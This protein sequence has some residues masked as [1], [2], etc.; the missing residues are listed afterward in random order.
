M[1]TE[2]KK[3]KKVVKQRKRRKAYEKQR[4]IMNNRSK[5]PK[6]LQR[7]YN[8]TASTRPIKP[9]VKKPSL[10][11]RIKAFFYGKKTD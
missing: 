8:A 3:F 2:L 10:W 5:K 6:S 4:N 1:T 11:Q 9:V 7:V